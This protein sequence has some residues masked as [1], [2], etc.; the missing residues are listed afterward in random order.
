MCMEKTKAIA[1]VIEMMQAHGV[2]MADLMHPVSAGPKITQIHITG[3]RWI[4][5]LTP[6]EWAA[7]GGQ[8]Y[9]PS[10]AYEM[11]FDTPLAVG[12]DGSVW[13]WIGP[14]VEVLPDKASE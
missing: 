4:E 8:A 11:E 6:Q 5:E 13:A 1:T 2:T 14:S 3:G 9:S 12:V 10:E 7:R